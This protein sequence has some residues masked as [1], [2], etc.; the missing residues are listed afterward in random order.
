MAEVQCL[1]GIWADESIQEQ[2]DTTQELGYFGK[3]NHNYLRA[4]GHQEPL[5]SVVES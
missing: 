2:L 4:R 5:S 1:L 3:K